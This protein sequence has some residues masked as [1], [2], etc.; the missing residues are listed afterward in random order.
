MAT[1]LP[2]DIGEQHVQRHEAV[3]EVPQSR[4][5]GW[6]RLRVERRVVIRI[7]SDMH[8]YDLALPGRSDDA[9]DHNLSR[10]PT[11]GALPSERVDGPAHRQI[12]GPVDDCD[13]VAVAVAIR[14]AEQRPG[15]WSRQRRG[16]VIRPA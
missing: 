6:Q 11:F 3:P 8:Q 13:G 16:S 12:P 7:G 2:L 1:V 10:D 9:L 15:D 4:D 5:N 14:E